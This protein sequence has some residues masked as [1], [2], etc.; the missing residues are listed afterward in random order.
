MLA[1]LPNTNGFGPWQAALS[2]GSRSRWP[3]LAKFE[4]FEAKRFYLR[5]N[6]V[7]R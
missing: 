1:I 2:W 7:Y 5:E 6:S 3:D 4:Q